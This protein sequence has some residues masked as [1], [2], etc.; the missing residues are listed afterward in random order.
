MAA[1]GGGKGA[2][3]V[4]VGLVR[5]VGGVYGGF[6]VVILLMCCA[7]RCALC[8]GCGI[9]TASW[10]RAFRGMRSY[11]KVAQRSICGICIK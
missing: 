6:E 4:E 9:L 1:E 7:K 5:L 3:E 8:G 11:S 10:T 2:G